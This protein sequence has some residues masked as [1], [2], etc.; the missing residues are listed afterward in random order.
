VPEFPLDAL[1]DTFPKP[2]EELMRHYRV[3][4]LLPATCTLVINSVALG[5]GV[6]TKSNVRRTYGNLYAIIG[7]LSGSGKTPP[8]EDLMV[9]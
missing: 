8:Y 4:A 7:A 5:R 9:R 6:V 3:P 2:V 1:P